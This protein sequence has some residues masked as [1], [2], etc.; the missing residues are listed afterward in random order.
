[1]KV[2]A[3]ICV[4]CAGLVAGCSSGKYYWC[5][6]DKTLDEAKQDCLQCISQADEEAR[7]HIDR[8]ERL[9]R[10]GANVEAPYYQR[11]I[12]DTEFG[13]GQAERRADTFR[14]CMERKGYRRVK[15]DN[16]A[17]GIGRQCGHSAPAGNC[18]AG[19]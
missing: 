1:M 8:Q 19:K 11:S 18:L 7:W 3:T 16:L 12:T 17:Q 10:L 14:T 15:E 2:L 9:E 5:R 6:S 13:H 4:L